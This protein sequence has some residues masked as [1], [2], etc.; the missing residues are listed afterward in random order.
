MSDTVK[1]LLLVVGTLIAAFICAF[2]FKWV[3][4]VIFALTVPFGLIKGGKY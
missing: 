3:L 2:M 1:T 4:I